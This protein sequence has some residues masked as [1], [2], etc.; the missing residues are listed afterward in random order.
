VKNTAFQQSLSIPP[1]VEKS[2]L[3]LTALEDISGLT[4]LS[5]YSV[6][7]LCSLKA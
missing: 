1:A 5:R 6:Q 4:S 7:S 2:V 3:Q